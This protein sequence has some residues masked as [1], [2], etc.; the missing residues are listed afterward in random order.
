M[1]DFNEYQDQ[2]GTPENAKLAR[3]ITVTYS[4]RDSV[5]WRIITDL[6]TFD[7]PKTRNVDEGD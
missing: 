3:P 5:P 6:F 1:C 2:A 7:V 4:W